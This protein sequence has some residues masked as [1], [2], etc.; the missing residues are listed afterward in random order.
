[1]GIGDVLG[2]FIEKK[3]AGLEF[4][5]EDFDYLRLAKMASFGALVSAPGILREIL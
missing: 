1:M 2:Q 4:H 3:Y 5:M